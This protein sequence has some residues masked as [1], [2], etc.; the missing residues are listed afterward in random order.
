MGL[1][2]IEILDV[3]PYVK[4]G[5][6]MQFGLN[7]DPLVKILKIVVVVAIVAIVG[8]ISSVVFF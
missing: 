1:S 3:Q 8:W 7:L 4:R 2:N 6:I 5:N